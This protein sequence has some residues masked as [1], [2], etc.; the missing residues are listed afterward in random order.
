MSTRHDEAPALAGV[1]LTSLWV[2]AMR[3]VETERPLSEGRLCEDPF[4]RALAGAEGF[5]TL[6][7]SVAELG[8]GPP[9]VPVRTRFC[10]DRL[11]AALDEGFE[12]IVILAAGMDSRAFRMDMKP[13][14]HVFEVDRAEIFAHKE[15]R[16]ERTRPRGVRTIVP[17]DLA[18]DWPRALVDRGMSPSRRTFWV[19]EG[20]LIYLEAPAVDAL[21]TRLDALSAPGSRA[22]FDGS[23]TAILQHP[24]MASRV[25]F[26]AKLGA[27]WIYGLDEP[28]AFTAR[29]GWRAQVTEHGELGARFAR[30]PYPVFP[31]TV[32]GVPRSHLVEMTKPAAGE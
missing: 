27:P 29:F 10:D 32:P 16:L 31:R 4:A 18:D 30:W 17:V 19:V 2:A 15:P 20:L 13:E 23:S 12:Q 22:I 5:A 7:R 24:I 11:R 1:G 14:V 26:V 28:E 6:E 3:A 25:A 21:F 9:V 8:I